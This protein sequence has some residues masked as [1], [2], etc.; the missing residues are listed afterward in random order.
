MKKIKF[1]KI[2]ICLSL[3]ILIIIII[4]Q[5]VNYYTYTENQKYLYNEYN[6]MSIVLSLTYYKD[7]DDF[8]NNILHQER[9]IKGERTTKEDL[10]ADFS[11]YDYIP[12]LNY[13]K[14]ESDI[15]QN[16]V[17]SFSK[18]M[19]F[20]EFVNY[21]NYN[22]ADT[23]LKT[24]SKGF[25]S[26]GNVITVRKKVISKDCFNKLFSEFIGG[27]QLDKIILDELYKKD[28]INE[29]YTF[30]EL[31][32]M[33]HNN[34]S[35]FYDKF[36]TDIQDVVADILGDF[37]DYLNSKCNI[38]YKEK[39]KENPDDIN[40]KYEIQLDME[41]VDIEIPFEFSTVQSLYNDI[42]EYSK[43]LYSVNLQKIWAN[44]SDENIPKIYI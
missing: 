12:I 33:F 16:V 15:N 17:E 1:N 19:D 10:I 21:Y 28:I 27:K 9:Y 5:L 13:I 20:I 40:Y 36:S 44:L 25:Y 29:L 3:I 31:D 41:Y 14:G 43:E 11:T 26:E 38:E 37:G 35:V 23:I 34:Y 18:I 22:P 4:W 6:R 32:L 30:E 2:T 42:S 7:F 8:M 39:D 24:N